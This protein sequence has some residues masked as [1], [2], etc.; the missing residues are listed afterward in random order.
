[1]EASLCSG[2]I[3]GLPESRFGGVIQEEV[4]FTRSNDSMKYLEGTSGRL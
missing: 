2:L 4:I 3:G 1:M